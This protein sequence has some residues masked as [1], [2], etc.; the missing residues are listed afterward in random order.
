M[1]VEVELDLD[2]FVSSPDFR[3]VRL[4]NLSIVNEIANL[5]PK[6]NTVLV[7]SLVNQIKSN[8]DRAHKTTVQC[9]QIF[10]LYKKNLKLQTKSRKIR[11]SG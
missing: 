9:R 5:N 1:E 11:E 4:T 3:F 2:V 10:F 6:R 8:R 7:G